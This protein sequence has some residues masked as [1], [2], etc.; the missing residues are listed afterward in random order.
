MSY[1]FTITDATDSKTIASIF[2]SFYLNSGRTNWTPMFDLLFKES[3]NIAYNFTVLCIEWFLA[4]SKVNYYDDRNEASVM[5]GRKMDS[6]CKFNGLSYRTNA[7]VPK[8]HLIVDGQSHADIAKMLSVFLKNADADRYSKSPQDYFLDEMLH[9]HKTLQQNYSRLCFDWFNYLSKQNTAGGT[10]YRL[11]RLAL[12][13][14][15]PLPYI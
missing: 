1:V 12:P 6:S 7:K 10:H 9:E 5:I 8:V 2:A 11:A 4:L 14:R 3:R 15:E 13:F